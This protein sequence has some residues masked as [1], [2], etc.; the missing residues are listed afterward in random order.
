MVNFI[1]AHVGISSSFFISIVHH[2][3]P[4]WIIKLTSSALLSHPNH[5]HYYLLD[6]RVEHVL[7]YH[8]VLRF[9]HTHTSRCMGG[10]LR[11]TCIR[12]C[13]YSYDRNIVLTSRWSLV[14]NVRVSHSTQAVLF[15][16]PWS[17]HDKLEKVYRGKLYRL[18]S[19]L[20][21]CSL[22]VWQLVWMSFELVVISPSVFAF[23]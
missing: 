22:F 20:A 2:T 11:N 13:T 12:G 21:S 3:S 17:N 5:C 8:R 18:H 19:I 15:H 23:C 4:K 9:L 16:F 7:D 1:L 6:L 14:H 10:C